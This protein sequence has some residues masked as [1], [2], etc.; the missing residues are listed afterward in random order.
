MTVALGDGW[1]GGLCPSCTQP[2]QGTGEGSGHQGVPI[3]VG[4]T[5]VRHLLCLMSSPVCEIS[6]NPIP[7]LQ[8]SEQGSSYPNTSPAS[9]CQ[10]LGGHL[11]DGMRSPRIPL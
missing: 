11:T 4:D 8:V 9:Q 1:T 6:S 7:V 3:T 5:V 2:T 10:D